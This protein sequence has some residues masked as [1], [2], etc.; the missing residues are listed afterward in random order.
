MRQIL[1]CVAFLVGMS[2]NGQSI[3][4]SSIDSGGASASNGNI[5]VLYTIGEVNVNES[6][7]GNIILSE[8][9]ISGALQIHINPKLF[10]EGPYDS[11]SS[12]LMFDYL[13]SSALI[14]LDT[15]Y[16]DG[17]SINASVLTVT[18]NNAIVDW[19][20]VELR[21]QGDYTNIVEATSALLQKDGDIVDVDGVSGL[22]FSSPANSYYIAIAHRNH[23]GIITDNPVNLA[24]TSALDLTNNIGLINGGVNAIS[25]MGDGYYALTGG[26]FN[27]NGQVQ[28]SDVTGV[29]PSIG[30]ATYSPSDIDMNGQTQNT[31]IANTLL[32]NIG[33]GEQISAKTSQPHIVIVAPRKEK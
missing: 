5:Q 13:R 1:L 16:I 14:P 31:D 9:F 30:T 23:L 11:G 24:T 18:G 17:K 7:A 4:K 6:S 3:Y 15:P 12:A 21:D 2:I 20:W 22:T 10:L 19:V 27:G 8:G 32:P 33:K 28:N 26:D 25:N 29:L